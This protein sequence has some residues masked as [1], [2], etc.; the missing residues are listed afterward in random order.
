MRN[1]LGTNVAVTLFGES[2]GDS[3]GA[4]IDGLPAGI[5]VDEEF[6]RAQKNSCD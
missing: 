2:H 3:I 4:V 6:I 1:T 5:R